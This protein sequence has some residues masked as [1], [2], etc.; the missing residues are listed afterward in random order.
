MKNL[1][2][3]TSRIP[4]K[5]QRGDQIRAFHQLRHLSKTVQITMICLTQQQENIQQVSALQDLGIEVHSF[6]LPKWRRYLALRHSVFSRIPFQVSYFYNK[7]IEKEVQSLIRKKSFDVIHCHLIRT[8]LYARSFRADIRSIDFMDA[9]G[10]GMNL[11][12][13]ENKNLLKRII[14]KSERDRLIHFETKSFDSFDRHFAISKQDALRIVHPRNSEIV[15]SANGV[16]FDQFYPKVAEK[17]YDLVFMGNMDYVPNVA[18]VTFIVNEIL[19]ELR[20]RVP[21]VSLLIAGRDATKLIQSY[22]CSYIDVVQQF[23]DISDAIASAKIMLAPMMISIGLQNKI[24]QSMAMKVPCITSEAANNAIGSIP[25]EHILTANTKNEFV[26]ETLKLLQ[27]QS[28][29]Y[30]VAESAYDF[31]NQNFTWEHCSQ[32]ILSS[33]S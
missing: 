13:S 30:S 10:F 32:Q 2:Y 29:R 16:D 20:K 25:N 5:D 23:D 26:R 22:Q 21:T 28:L 18:A 31:V 6:Y 3:I 7:G 24:L 8:V 17:K 14:L 15:I 4:A 19:P 11:R 33:I 27:D 9:Y 12:Y 1:L